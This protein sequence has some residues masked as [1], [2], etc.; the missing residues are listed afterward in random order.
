MCSAFFLFNQKKGVFMNIFK[1]STLALAIAGLAGGALAQSA[2]APVPEP[3]KSPI[4]A[5][6]TVVNDYR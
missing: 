5:N 6:V 4:T 1:K 3:E 2:P